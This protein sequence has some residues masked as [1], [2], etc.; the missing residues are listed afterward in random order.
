MSSGPPEASDRLLPTRPGR[1][2]AAVFL[3]VVTLWTLG[4]CRCGKRARGSDASGDA[5]AEFSEVDGSD[6]TDVEGEGLDPKDCPSLEK[7]LANAIAAGPITKWRLRN[8]V[9][10]MLENCAPKEGTAPMEAGAIASLPLAPESLVA[11][12]CTALDTLKKTRASEP[13]PD[14]GA[15]DSA[16][17]AAL[18][19]VAEM[20]ERSPALT[21][22][23]KRPEARTTRELV[24]QL[25]NPAEREQRR[26]LKLHH[27]WQGEVRPGGLGQPDSLAVTIDLSCSPC[28]EVLTEL[29]AQGLKPA[30]LPVPGRNSQMRCATKEGWPV[31]CSDPYWN[32]FDS[33]R[34]VLSR[35]VLEVPDAGAPTVITARLSGRGT[36]VSEPEA[37]RFLPGFVPDLEEEQVSPLFVRPIPE[38]NVTGKDRYLVA[39]ALRSV[40]RSLPVEF[41]S[42]RGERVKVLHR[43][44]LDASLR[45]IP[46][47]ERRPF[48]VP[49]RILVAELE[50]PQHDPPY[51]FSF[52]MAAPPGD[53]WLPKP[54]TPDPLSAALME[55]LHRASTN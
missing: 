18:A 29:E 52:R 19:S 33:E 37:V 14:G 22:A 45:P 35:H 44:E 8:L 24:W 26:A 4:G 34:R 54:E 32:P 51:S 16:S 31:D 55:R 36:V 40:R 41:G 1:M 2:L 17:A 10:P 50:T 30:T 6:E 21:A 49:F 3:C 11:E 39:L 23:C 27:A 13:G 53:V 28:P 20:A 38:G 47:V 9:V 7:R 43:L 48:F 25:S 12:I 15:P 5:P 46:S 42:R